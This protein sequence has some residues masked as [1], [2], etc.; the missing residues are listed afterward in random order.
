MDFGLALAISFLVF[1][2]A[3]LPKEL[4]KEPQ[5]QLE[6]QLPQEKLEKHLQKP[7]ACAQLQQEQTLSQQEQAQQKLAL[8]QPA[9]TLEYFIW[10]TFAITVLNALIWIGTTSSVFA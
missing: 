1:F 2:I 6:E 4:L 5:K 3:V 7:S 10:I 8:K 9:S